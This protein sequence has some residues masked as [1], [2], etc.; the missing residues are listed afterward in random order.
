MLELKHGFL[1]QDQDTARIIKATPTDR[2]AV[3]DTP[4]KE[5]GF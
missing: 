4:I 2:T 3:S 1:G 5:N